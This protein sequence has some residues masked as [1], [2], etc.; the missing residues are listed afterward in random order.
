MDDDLP[1]TLD[2]T[3]VYTVEYQRE[4]A[5]QLFLCL[6]VYIRPLLVDELEEILAIQS[7]EEHPLPLMQPGVKRT[8]KKR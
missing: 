2:E 3:Y 4:F 8:Q 5:Q 1:E 6:A 7:D